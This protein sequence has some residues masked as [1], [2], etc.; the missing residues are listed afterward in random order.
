M[1]APT[2]AQ[3]EADVTLPTTKVEIKPAGIW[4]DVT[5]DVISATDALEASGELAGFAFGASGGAA[6]SV[7]VW[8]TAFGYA[9]EQAPIRISYG[10]DT[11][12]VVRRFVGLIVGRSRGAAAGQWD[13]RGWDALIE[14]VRIRSPLFHRRPAATATTVTSIED[15]ANL[16][17]SG[18]LINYILWECGG[19]PDA[20]A[21]TYPNATFY[22]AC[23]QALIAPEWSWI[24]GD[25]AWEE[26]D[27]LCRACG[28]QLYQD[29][30]GVV[31]YVEPLNLAAGVATFGYTDSVATA[32]TAALR[33]AN[34]RS[35]YAD[36]SDQADAYRAPTAVTCTYVSRIVQG[37]QQVYQ[38]TTPK[39]VE[40]SAVLTLECDTQLPLYSVSRVEVKT[41]V[42]RTGR[43]P[44]AAEVAVTI[45][46]ERAQRVTVEVDNNLAEPVIIYQVLIFG[47]PVTAGEEGSAFYSASGA[48]V[49][50]RALPLEDNPYI[51]SASHARRLCRMAFDFYS[52]PRPIIT[53]AGCGYD[54]DRYVGEPIVLTSS[55]WGYTDEP[56]RIVAL[57]PDNGEFMDVDVCPSDGLPVGNEFYQVG[58]SY[59]NSASL[60]LSY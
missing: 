51:Q 33:V 24:T 25:N 43:A 58:Q 21:A 52:D 5:A 9:W 50:E 53:L 18:G 37:V 49:T 47:R 44:T 22:Y 2:R 10:F 1:A 6:A 38:D 28:G 27:R 13:C 29:V 17:Y 31:R 23:D 48:L 40:G 39:R 14:G 11:S 42:L 35:L 36:I 57:R 30:D 59:G 20:Q 60:Q 12:D 55:D 34:S 3:I 56:C 8:K 19:R 16:N 41:A 46:D 15:P 7:E 54:P 32:G 4:L 26:L 45:T